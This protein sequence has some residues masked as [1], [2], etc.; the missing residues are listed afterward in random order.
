MVM[1]PLDQMRSLAR[2]VQLANAARQSLE[3]PADLVDVLAEYLR[4]TMAVAED[5]AWFWSAD[6]QAGEREAEADVAAGRVQVFDSMDDLLA[7][8][9]QQP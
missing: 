5:Q 2:Q 3:V 1:I 8:L 4:E 6:W 7:D 9:E